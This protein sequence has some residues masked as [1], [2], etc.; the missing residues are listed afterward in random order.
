M[1]SFLTELKTEKIEEEALD[2]LKIEKIKI[3]SEG[4]LDIY[5][6]FNN[7]YYR[8]YNKKINIEK[9]INLIKLNISERKKFIAEQQL[10]I[11]VKKHH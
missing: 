9:S 11:Q 5:K 4:N 6:K 10:I 3:E 7:D 2:A 8:K 1:Y